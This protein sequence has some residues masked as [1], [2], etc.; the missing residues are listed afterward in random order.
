MVTNPVLTS[1][2]FLGAVK[3]LMIVLGVIYAV[4]AVILLRQIQMMHTMVK[5]NV[6]GLMLFLGV[7][8]LGLVLLLLLY[9][10]TL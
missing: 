2:L 10:L 4:Y 9:F 7:G 8:H 1:P 6:A 3:F 5:T